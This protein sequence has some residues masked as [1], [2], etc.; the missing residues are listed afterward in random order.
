[1][2]TYVAGLIAM[3]Y[4]IAGLFFCRFWNRTRDGLFMMFAIAFWLLAANHTLVALAG[5]TREERTWFYLLRLAG[6]VLI[7]IGIAAKNF[8]PRRSP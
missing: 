1:M 6:F 2:E 3:G 7:I 5:L 4:F 8:G